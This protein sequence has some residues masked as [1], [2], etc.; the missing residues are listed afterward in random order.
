MTKTTVIAALAL[1]ALTGAA[2]A[3]QRTSHDAMDGLGA[4]IVAVLVLLALAASLAIYFLPHI[5]AC[6]K[7]HPNRRA[8]FWVNLLLGGSGAGWLVA[9]I[10]AIVGEARSGARDFTNDW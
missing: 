6:A 10:W 2:Q 8:I 5:I 3:L 1:A 4:I 7:N 9:L